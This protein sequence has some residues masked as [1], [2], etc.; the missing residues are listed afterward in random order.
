MPINRELFRE[1]FARFLA[2]VQLGGGEPF[3][4]FRDG[5][6]AKEENYKEPLRQEALNRLRPDLITEL[7]I[8]KG[9]IL[10]RLISSI[11]I[12]RAPNLEPNNLVRW[13]NRYGHAN[14]SHHTLLD[15]LEDPALTREIE[16]WAFDFYG[17]RLDNGAAFERLREIVGAR[18][19]LLAYLFF[20]KDSNQYMPIATKTFDSAFAALGID[21]V[22]TQRCSWENYQRYNGA[23]EDIRSALTEIAGRQYVRL[24]DAHSFCWIL[25]REEYETAQIPKAK[26]PKDKDVGKIFSARERS[27]WRMAE[28][29]LGTIKNANGQQVSVTKKVKELWIGAAQLEQY[30]NALLEKQEEKCALTGIPLQYDGE[31]LDH[32]LLPSLDRIDSSG[33]Y[34]EGNLQVVCKFVNKWKSDEKND[35]FIRLLGLVRHDD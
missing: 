21:L 15:A 6:A 30:V 24:V 4:S 35:E 32:Q 3:Q 18:Y 20:L 9:Q 22:T 29:T 25:I 13:E 33:H 28:T 2:R 19:D 26:A 16:R 7:D 27:V 17:D 31:H 12:A 11:E 8:G 14:R 5:F 1:Q 23:L 34:A 10:A